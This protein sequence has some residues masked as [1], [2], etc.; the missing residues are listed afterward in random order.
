[1]KNLNF[2]HILY[3]IFPIV[4]YFIFNYFVKFE[5]YICLMGIILMELF[6]NGYLLHYKIEKLKLKKEFPDLPE[7]DWTKFIEKNNIKWYR[8]KDTHKHVLFI[9]NIIFL[10]LLCFI[11][12]YEL[13][14]TC[15]LLI[16][17]RICL[18]TEE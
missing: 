1:M 12:S 11:F 6:L 10:V 13:L 16:T 18:H 17:A 15:L 3:P 7:H 8:F 4:I 2:K 14:Y 5:W 9:M